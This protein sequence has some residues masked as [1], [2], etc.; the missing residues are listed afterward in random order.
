M[1]DCL[2]PLA[3]D[4]EEL[5]RLALDDEALSP[6]A[7]RHLEQCEICRQRLATYKDTQTFLVSHLYRRQCPAGSQL[8][9]YCAGLLA[10]DERQRIA[11]HI[12][13]CPLCTQEVAETRRFMKEPLLA[14]TPVS[15]LRRVAATLVRQ[16][17]QLVVRGDT[18][19]APWPRQYH[20]EHIDLSL[21]LSRASNGAYILLGIITSADSTESVDAFAGVQAELYRAPGPSGANGGEDKQ[22]AQ[23]LVC[24]NIDELGNIVFSAVPAGEYT[25][26]AHLPG[27]ELL[28]EGLTIDTEAPNGKFTP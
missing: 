16:Q 20:A 19:P 9:Y 28:I 4:D 5:L 3:P 26:L 7:S 24:T 12:R 11:A 25:L 18:T 14:S 15:P 27:Y 17:A 1:M 21:H 10:G 22:A 6:E 13:E 8:S 2:H 23:P